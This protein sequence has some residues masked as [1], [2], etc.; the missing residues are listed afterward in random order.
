MLKESLNQLID[1]ATSADYSKNIIDARKEYQSIAGNIYEDDKSYENRMSLFL[2]WYIF[3][4]IYSDTNQTLIETLLQKN[5]NA[6]SPDMLKTFESYSHNIHGL[7]I[8]KK[9]KGDF[10]KAL[11]LFDNSTY[12]V[13]QSFGKIIFNKNL[14]FEG[15]LVP[16]D[17]S[18]YFT[19]SFCFHPDKAIKFIKSKTNYINKINN[20]NKKELKAITKKLD[21]NKKKILKIELKI[22]DIKSK[23]LKSSS[24]KKILQLNLI[25]D[26]LELERTSFEKN[27]IQLESEVHQFTAEKIILGPKILQ[28]QLI[29]KL[30]YMQLV[31]ERSRLIDL[32]DIYKN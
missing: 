1:I 10:V 21:L 6:W 23:I 17:N 16:Y 13:N 28:T 19:G 24:T 14:V 8:V 12:V 20:K 26:E 3:D 32:N 30:S 31:W 15:R 25:L 22:D 4:R 18:Y 29:Q 7:F 11:N 5:K 27:Y 2:E 9:I